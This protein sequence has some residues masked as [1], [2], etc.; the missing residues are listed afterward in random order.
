VQTLEPTPPAP[1]PKAAWQA[2]HKGPTLSG[3]V[4]PFERSKGTGLLTG[5]TLE[6][7]N[8]ALKGYQAV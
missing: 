7:I 2:P 6:Q 5:R 4:R 3:V 1:P 8:M